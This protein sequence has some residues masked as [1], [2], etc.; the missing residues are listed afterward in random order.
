MSNM[1]NIPVSQQV[2]QISQQLTVALVKSVELAAQKEAND[3]EVAAIRNLL[4]GIQL[5]QALQKEIDVEQGKAA[6]PPAAPPK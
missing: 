2:Q 1:Q 3:K 6:T 4:A 5:G